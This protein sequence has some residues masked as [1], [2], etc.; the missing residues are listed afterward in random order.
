MIK[1]YDV[2]IGGDDVV[3]VDTVGAKI[4][5]YDRN[6]IKHLTIATEMGV[7]CGN[8]DEIEIV[9][10]I[11]QF[12]PRVPHAKERIYPP[13]LNIKIVA[14]KEMACRE[15]CLGQVE[16]MLDTLLFDANGQGNFTIVAGKGFSK[17]DLKDLQEP[18]V[19]VGDCPT[20]EIGSYV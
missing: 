5:G 14:G 6:E 13:E 3:A 8:L 20:E 2:L 7:G 15:G 18:I 19:V 17:S 12:K 16:S 9:G 1:V 10:N 11:K 4:L